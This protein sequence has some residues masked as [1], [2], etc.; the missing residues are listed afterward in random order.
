VAEAS[1]DL[2]LAQK[3]LVP[4]R[5]RQVRLDDLDGDVAPVFSSRAR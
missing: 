4:E 1:S 2:D 5:R 3:A